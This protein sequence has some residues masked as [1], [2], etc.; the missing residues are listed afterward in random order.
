MTKEQ[1]ANLATYS[2]AQEF[3]SKPHSIAKGAGGKKRRKLLDR[4]R[5]KPPK[6]HPGH[7]ANPYMRP[8]FDAHYRQVL[9]SVADSIRLELDKAVTRLAKK[10][11]RL[12][13][14]G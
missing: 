3:G 7:A 13:A 6:L 9:E 14:K 5:R 8:A 12:A 11:A 1:I 10:A 2:M 4:V